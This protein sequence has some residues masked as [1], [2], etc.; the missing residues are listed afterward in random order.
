VFGRL[1]DAIIYLAD[2]IHERRT[3]SQLDDVLSGITDSLT[4]VSA[5]LTK[6]F[7]EI[8]EKLDTLSAG[9]TVDPAVLDE[10]KATVA[11]L[12]GQAQALDDIVPDDVDEPEDDDQLEINPL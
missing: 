10:L 12:A 8:T 3:M 5:Q 9:D 4:E 7:G 2:T 1:A 11:T 6:G